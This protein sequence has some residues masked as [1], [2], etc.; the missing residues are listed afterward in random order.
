MELQHKPVKCFVT[1][2]LFTVCSAAEV[3]SS[4]LH[5]TFDAFSLSSV[6]LGLRGFHVTGEVFMSFTVTLLAHAAAL[7]TRYQHML[8]WKPIKH[9]VTVHLPVSVSKNDGEISTRQ[10]HGLHGRQLDR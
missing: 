6:R 10:A 3:N 2:V 7:I 5:F 4:E 8:M 9:N 1:A